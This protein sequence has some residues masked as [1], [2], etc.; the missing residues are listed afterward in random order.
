MEFASVGAKTPFI[1]STPSNAV[2]LESPAVEVKLE[3]I[4]G[5]G[6]GLGSGLAA[7][8]ALA[9][10]LFSGLLLFSA[11]T[12]AAVIANTSRLDNQLFSFN[13]DGV[14][15]VPARLRPC[16]RTWWRTLCRFQSR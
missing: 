15:L 5:L 8:S 2:T 1:T 6:L 11:M 4:L 10:L 16:H 13:I 14:L 7:V 9:A 12:G 3:L